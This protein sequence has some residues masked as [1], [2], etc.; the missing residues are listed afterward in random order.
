MA[1]P[2]RMEFPGA[3]YHVICRG[4]F[5]NP[6]FSESVD[7]TLVMD[8]FAEFAEAFAV[9]IRAYCVMV[10]HLHC[11]LQTR[12]GNLGRY[13]QSVLTSFSVIYNRRRHTSGHV[14][15]GRYKALLVEDETGYSANVSRYIHLNPACTP[16]LADAEF[17]VRRRAIREYEWSSYAALLGLR[18]RPSWLRRQE[19]FRNWGRTLKDKQQQYGAFVEQ[20]LTGELWDPESA[21]AAQCLIGSDSFVDRVRRGLTELSE[22]VNVRRESV[23]SRALHSWCT[24]EQLTGLV[25]E[26]YACSPEDLLRPHSKGNEGRQV[27]LYLASVYCR[28]RYSLSELGERLG[29]VSISGLGSA[30]Q[31]MK[32][33]L[34]GCRELRERVAALEAR[35][36]ALKSRSED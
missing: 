1:R 18:K 4:N 13:M 15:Q 34:R 5:R 36:S 17:D 14:F 21:A 20:G 35:I 31:I 3:C 16:S 24:L 27:L 32:R 29:P 23:Q 19:A 22:N 30:R 28:G 7:R 9:R 25:A 26:A 8:R 2:L 10:N 12:E 6:V 33:R 11:H